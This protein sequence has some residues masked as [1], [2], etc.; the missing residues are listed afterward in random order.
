[1]DSATETNP[2]LYLERNAKVDPSGVFMQSGEQTIL[3]SEALT[4][5]KKLAYEFR[6]LGMKPGDLVALDLPE[7][8]SILFTE[9][10]FHE[11]AA[12]TVLPNGFVTDGAFTIDWTFSG[13]AEEPQGGGRIITVDAGF[14]DRVEQ[15]PYGISPR[16]YESDQSLV[17][18]MFS[19]G[20]T[21]RPN[22][23]AVTLRKLDD[24][25]VTAIDTWMQGDP[26]LTF[27]GA[28][29]PLGLYAVYISVRKNQPF[30]AIGTSDAKATIELAARNSV[31]S[32]KASPVQL[33]SLVDEL[34]AQ[35]RT[36]PRI[37]TVYTVGTAMAPALAARLRRVTDDCE[38][39]GLYGATEVGMAFVRYYETDDPFDVG[40]LFPG[41]HIQ[42][43]DDDDQVLP[44][45]Q[46]GRIRL[47]GPVMVHEYLG[48]P[49]GT[50]DNF[51]DG[52]F[53]PGDLG[54]IRPDK[55]LTLR[56]RSSEILNAGGVKIDPARL[57]LFAVSRPQ[58][59]DAAS[60]GY[61]STSGLQQ[62]GIALV[63]E[64]GLD[65]QALI[66]EFDSEFGTAAPKL[67][68]RVAQIPRNAMGK[69]MRLAL[70]ETHRES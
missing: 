5:V 7:S 58:V 19:S 55:G 69:P 12:S 44:D 29:T 66:R 1:V 11:A 62:I 41:A 53:Y 52:W 39:Y 15:N 16:A 38:I 20:T 60:F 68:A 65:V 21:G 23:I 46:T 43:V 18:V 25:A 49:E 33:A 63:T 47:Q 14:L 2:F 24:Y 34:E 59:L 37:Q 51:S 22:A 31:T 45:G 36:L 3:N 13:A 35:N 61:T 9:A 8:L 6:R 28:A 50:R 27:M 48:N 64:D 42:I 10:V 26:F 57:D 67:V 40:Q 30:L 54:M 56:G 17:W 70:A 32:L 4:N